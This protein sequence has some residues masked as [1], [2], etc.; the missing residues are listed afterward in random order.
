MGTSTTSA[1]P[2]TWSTAS[3][4]WPDARRADNG[5]HSHRLHRELTRRRIVSILSYRGTTGVQGLGQLRYVVEQ[6]LARL[7]QFTRLAVRFERHLDLHQALV[8]RA[9]ALICRRRLT[10]QRPRSC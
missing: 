9:C 2:W 3:H 5:Y 6:T 7:P 8:C 1:R 10:N 4:R